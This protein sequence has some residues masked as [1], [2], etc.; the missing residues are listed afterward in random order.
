MRLSS[1]ANYLD[2]QSPLISRASLIRTTF[3]YSKTV[4]LTYGIYA[5][6]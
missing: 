3:L 5:I 4:G 1:L 2:G 6:R